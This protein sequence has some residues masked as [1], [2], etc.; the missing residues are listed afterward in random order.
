MEIA[1]LELGR[2][3]AMAAHPKPLALV[4]DARGN[5]LPRGWARVPHSDGV[6]SRI[7]TP[8]S[9]ESQHVV[10]RAPRLH[11]SPDCEIL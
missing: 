7:H 5:F 10:P 8:R 11:A 4:V 3:M 1:L 9:V 6:I 2:F